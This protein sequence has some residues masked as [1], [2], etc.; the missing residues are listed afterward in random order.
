M[1][2]L[3]NAAV[4]VLPLLFAPFA[5]AGDPPKDL[6]K[7]DLALVA[8][9]PATVGDCWY[10]ILN[11][12]ALGGGTVNVYSWQYH[13]ETALCHNENA[14]SGC[15]GTLI[16]WEFYQCVGRGDI[17]YYNGYAPDWS[18]GWTLDNKGHCHFDGY[19]TD[20]GGAFSSYQVC[21][22]DTVGKAQ[23]CH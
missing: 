19:G 4:M 16:G 23:S 14:G 20:G 7:H 9:P 21:P 13:Y 8:T 22:C 5:H 2:L 15:D 1:Q 12:G 17:Y 11:Y 10:L 18:Q 6:I 3:S